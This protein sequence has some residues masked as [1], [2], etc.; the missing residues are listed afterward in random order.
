MLLSKLHFYGIW[1]TVLKWFR[2]YLTERKLRVEIKS[3]SKIFLKLGNNKTWS[4]PR[5]NPR[6]VCFS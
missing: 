4:S 3:H 1:G 6:A 2:Y 5:I